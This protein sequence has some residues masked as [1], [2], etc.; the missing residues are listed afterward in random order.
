LACAIAGLIVVLLA[1]WHH[2]PGVAA[3]DPKTIGGFQVP[4]PVV[5]LQTPPYPAE[6]L[7]LVDSLRGNEAAIDVIVGQG[8]L[9]TLQMPL[10]GPQG[11]AV[12][13]VGDP[14]VLDFALLPNPRMIR[15]IGKRVGVTDLSVIASDGQAIQF[16]VHVVYDLELLRTQLG[17]VFPD[18]QLRLA[19]LQEH[20]IVEGEARNTTRMCQIVETLDGYL[21]SARAM[22]SSE[23]LARPRLVNLIRVPEVPQVM[24][25]VRIAEVNRALL[26][27]VEGSTASAPGLLDS[28]T[29]TSNGS[30][31]F[32]LFTNADCNHLIQTLRNN[33]AIS[34]L[35]EPSLIVLS[36]HHA[37]FLAD[38]LVD[39]KDIG[40]RLDVVPCVLD[41]GIIRLAVTPEVSSSV[42][43]PG[44]SPIA[45]GPPVPALSTQQAATTVELRQGQ[46][47]AIA[48]L[49]QVSILAETGH[50][51]FPVIGRCF[52][53][54]SC[55]RV[56]REFLFLITPCLVGP[57]PSEVIRR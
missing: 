32:D 9:L 42:G 41:E 55:R 35:A 31:A 47:L 51:S 36:G 22:P 49:K 48:G 50:A 12:V 7:L 5:P 43:V 10:A 46:T 1:G 4:L 57:M 39:F 17:Q 40:V 30:M 52:S 13:A 20:L 2:T 25:Q 15:L 27:D 56:E 18:A 26:R 44:A 34:I 23:S 3:A 45:C 19:Q 29:I 53:N 38:G 54:T 24:L 33:A 6:A 11:A 8:R 28:A 37:A 16:E 21:A 14:T